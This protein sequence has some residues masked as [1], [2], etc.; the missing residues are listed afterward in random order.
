MEEKDISEAGGKLCEEIHK[1]VD[2]KFN[3]IDKYID[4]NTE[5]VRKLTASS[6]KQDQILE[7]LQK[8][9]PASSIVATNIKKF[10]E[11]K[12]FTVVV[13]TSCV[14][15]ILVLGAAIGQNVLKEYADII[16]IGTG[17]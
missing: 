8:R 11:Y 17:N 3:Y 13:I 14:A 10:Y 1:R 12:W 4:S 16:K 5:A 7:L 2:E 9:I 15:L 6:I